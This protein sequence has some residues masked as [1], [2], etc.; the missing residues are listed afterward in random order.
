MNATVAP[1]RRPDTLDGPSKHQVIEAGQE[2]ARRP[3][4]KGGPRL[5]GRSVK[6]M[7]LLLDLS[8]FALGLLLLSQA[9]LDYGVGPHLPRVAVAAFEPRH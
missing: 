4:F 5:R 2:H 6:M 8:S 9:M 1:S 7:L 3:V